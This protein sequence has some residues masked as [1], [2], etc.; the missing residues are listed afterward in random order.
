MPR[1][2]ESLRTLSVVTRLTDPF[3]SVSSCSRS[4]SRGSSRCCDNHKRR[5]LT[6]ALALQL[7]HCHRRSHRI[8]RRRLG[9]L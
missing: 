3:D 5:G 4:S 9:G 1:G 7:H 6:S 8:Q 2:R